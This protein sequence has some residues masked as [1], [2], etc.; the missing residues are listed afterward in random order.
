MHW[1]ETA[2]DARRI[3]LEICRKAGAKAVNK[4]KT[5]I[6]EECGINDW[7]AE[8]GIT[9]VETDLGEYIIQLRG[10]I[11]SHIIAPAIHVTV[12]EVEAAFR[13]AHTHLPPDRRLSEYSDLLSEARAVL[14]AKY[15]EAEVGITGA[16]MLIAET[17]HSVIVT[18]EGNGDLSQSLPRVHIVMASLEKIVP[19]LDD[20]SVILRLLGRSATGQEMSVYTT[21][22]RGP[23]RPGD[24]DGPEEYH[25]VL[26]DNGRS[27][28]VGT[29]MQ[30][31]LRCIRCGACMNHCPVYQA[32]GGHAYGWVYPGPMGAVLTPSLIG[33][34]QGGQLPNASTFCGRCEAVCPVRIPLPKL[35]RHWREREFEKRLTPGAVRTG[36]GVWAYLAARPWLYRLATRVGNAG[37][38]GDGRRPRAARGRCRWPAAGP[39]T[40]DFPAPQGRT[41]MDQWKAGPAVSARERILG[42]LA[43]R[44]RAAGGR[45][46]RR[47]SRRGW[48][49]IRAGPV[50]AQARSHGPRAAGAVHGQGWRRRRRRW[51]GCRRS[52]SCR[53]RWR[54]SCASAT[55]RRRCASATDPMFAGLDWGT[56][57]TSQ[58][59]GRI[60]EPATL[61]RA[62]FGLAETGTLVL[63]SGPDNPV[64]LTFLGETHFVVLR[65]ADICGGF[66]D[67]WERLARVRATTRARSTSSPGRRA[68]PTSAR[69]CSSA[70]TGRWRCMSS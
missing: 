15:F 3:V 11:P 34:E 9:P 57:E 48:P 22:S 46:A 52:P 1:A 43:A 51:A 27:N 12:P 64:T 17:G 33:V 61:S 18:N 6:S 25:V 62:A 4:G 53:R 56:I 21:F 59:V 2:E 41:F 60:E 20:A 26:L 5:M 30:E 58:G 47:R 45:A 49:G 69:C 70:R 40:R 38:A 55:C 67:F 32:V 10:E 23:R 44:G 7:L 14:R 68:R 37:A 35:M 19:T 24:P 31:M 29:E 36:L 16:N 28:M 65:E 42:R 63:A 54:T 39:G 8:N 13:K 50:P 66:E